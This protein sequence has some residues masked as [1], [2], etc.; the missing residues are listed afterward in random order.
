[1]CRNVC[2]FCFFAFILCVKLM[3]EQKN[4]GLDKK[5]EDP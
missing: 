5:K 1:M 2:A 3:S 4:I